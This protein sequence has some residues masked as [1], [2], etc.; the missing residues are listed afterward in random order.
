M[1]DYV[2]TLKDKVYRSGHGA[3]GIALRKKTRMKVCRLVL[4]GALWA[5]LIGGCAPMNA[6][7]AIREAETQL[8]GAQKARADKYAPYLYFMAHSYLEKAK[9]T[10]G[11]S[12]FGAA[13]QYGLRAKD[14]AAKASTEARENRLR[15]KILNQRLKQRDKVREAK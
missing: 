7:S 2:D 12:E 13:E 10:E 6:S 8:D 9:L 1:G 14:L 15:Q 3:K 5:F 11:Y 4:F